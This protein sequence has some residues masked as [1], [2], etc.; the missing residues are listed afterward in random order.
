MQAAKLGQRSIRRADEALTPV[1]LLVG[2][3]L[4]TLLGGGF[5]EMAFGIVWSDSSEQWLA[6]IAVAVATS[7]TVAIVDR[8]RWPLGVFVSP[9]RGA[10]DF[11]RGAAIAVGVVGLA[12]LL[13]LATTTAR[14]AP[15]P[16]I[17]LAEWIAV[18]TPAAIH[19]ELLFRGYAF[20]RLAAWNQT[21]SIV[22]FS[23]LFAVLHL[24]NEGV[25]AIA[26]VNL[27]LGSLLLCVAFLVART[28]WMPIGL[29]LMWN[30][31]SG[32]LLGHEVSGYIPR[33]SLTR[34]IDHGP[35]LL[36]GGE[37]GIEASLYLTF[38]L[39]VASVTCFVVLRRNAAETAAVD[40][41]S[42]HHTKEFS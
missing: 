21:I 16:G 5:A 26:F 12:H 34:L 30:L 17:H 27:V 19:E 20:Q 39:L 29:H 32:P 31:F 18:F 25:N 1:V 3:Y 15:G 14:H 33:A 36:T 7:A 6:L 9:R 42:R 22:I 11:L 41:E 8:G 10:S 13:I 2:F 37:F 38:S 4:A 24:G 28:L 40:R 35:V 23:F